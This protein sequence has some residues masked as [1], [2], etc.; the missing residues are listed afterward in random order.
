MTLRIEDA[1]EYGV[2]AY[3]ANAVWEDGPGLNC[4]VVYDL[5]PDP[6]PD[7]YGWVMELMRDEIARQERGADTGRD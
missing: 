2:T 6:P 1:D 3:T 7:R 4:W 5:L